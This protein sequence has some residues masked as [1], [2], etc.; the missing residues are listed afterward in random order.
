MLHITSHAPYLLLPWTLLLVPDG[1][2]LCCCRQVCGHALSAHAWPLLPL[3]P[4]QL[5]TQRNISLM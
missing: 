1:V 4:P 3:L 2:K 5:H